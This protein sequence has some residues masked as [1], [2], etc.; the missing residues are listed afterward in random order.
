[1]T[2]LLANRYEVQR[3]LSGGGFSQTFLA[4]DLHLPGQPI[5]VVKQLQPKYSNTETLK[6]AK[7][8]FDQEAEVLYKLG[9]AH[10]QIPDLL[11]HFE[12]DGEFYLVQEFVD[13]NT[14]DQEI[15]PDE[16]MGEVPVIA[17][18]KDILSILSFVH[19]HQVIHRDIK[20][21]NLIRRHIDGQIVLIDFGAVKAV[22]KPNSAQ[23]NLGSALTI[24]VG[25]PGYMPLEQA[26][27]QPRFCSDVYAVGV[28][29]LCALTGLSPSQL[30][31]D[32]Q[33]QI[34][35]RHQPVTIRADLAMVIDRMIRRDYTQR[36]ATAGDALTA[37]QQILNEVE[38]S[39]T[40]ISQTASQSASQTAA[41]NLGQSLE[42]PSGQVPLDSCF[43]IERPPMEARCY[44]AISKP[45]ALIRIKAPRQVGKSSLMIRILSYARQQGYKATWLSLQRANDGALDNLDDFLKWLCA[46][47][48]RN[49]RLPNQ[50][51]SFWQQEASLG[52]NDKCTYYFEEHLLEK[53][54]VP[55]ALCL[56]EVDELFKHEDIA[57]D[58][59]GLL[60]AWHEEAKISP[61]WRNLRLMITHSKE[62]YIPLNINQSPFNVGLPIELAPFTIDQVEDLIRRHG[63]D[64]SASDLAEM[65][66]LTG[67]HPYLVRVALYYLARQEISL[68]QLLAVAPTQE[69]FYGDHL[70]HHLETL[71]SNVK[72][73]VAMQQVVQSTEP[74]RVDEAFKLASMGL[75]K[76]QGNDVV[77]LCGLYRQY[78]ADMLS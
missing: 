29:A 47:V 30:E 60:R 51:E 9:Q 23:P 28:L 25:S 31:V 48:S 64:W 10:P 32:D 63:L 38:V 21:T 14:L 76:F 20:P 73:K 6:I 24:S 7:R 45:G 26:A 75:V 49:L 27:G 42:E 22:Q 8:L 72:L 61:L 40:T 78:F 69:W 12:Q 13:G 68:P 53:L 54:S 3:H 67:G 16:P 56:D 34:T 43:Y 39:P 41:T 77:P 50:V 1:M 62:V 17:L 65:M 18:L 15:R 74:V 44:E 46:C 71:Q 37:L 55:L 19:H 11:A 2:F 58:F 35:C 70:R 57:K 52:S 66:N 33:L 4:K 36:Y 59:L 5:C